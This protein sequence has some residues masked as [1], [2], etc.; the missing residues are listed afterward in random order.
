MPLCPIKR[1]LFKVIAKL[2][3][4]PLLIANR[5]KGAVSGLRQL[6]ATEM[7]IEEKCFSFHLESFFRSNALCKLP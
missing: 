4:N 1:R 6:L 2:H 3:K 5:V 7:K